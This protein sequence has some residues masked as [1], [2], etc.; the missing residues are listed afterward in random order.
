MTYEKTIINDLFIAFVLACAKA[1]GFRAGQD[2]YRQ[3]RSAYTG[4]NDIGEFRAGTS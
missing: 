1:P 3:W 2:P 4:R